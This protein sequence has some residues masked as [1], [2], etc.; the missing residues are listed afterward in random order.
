MVGMEHQDGVEIA[1]DLRVRLFARELPQEICGVGEGIVR[2]HGFGALPYPLPTG[3]D[4]RHAA[5]KPDGLGHV[6]RAGIII[7]VRVRRG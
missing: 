7:E 2:G 1:G 4:H 5:D 6:A 3:H